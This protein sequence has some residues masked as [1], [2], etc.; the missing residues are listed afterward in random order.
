MRATSSARLVFPTPP[1]PTSNRSTLAWPSGSR[2]P[3]PTPTRETD[4]DGWD[5]HSS[6]SVV[7]SAAPVGVLISDVDGRIVQANDTKFTTFI[8]DF[9][10]SPALARRERFRGLLLPRSNHEEASLV[11][12]LLGGVGNL[13]GIADLTFQRIVGYVYR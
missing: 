7:S 3:A 12:S 10:I 6:A 13:F 8:S 11:A 9:T 5:P 2:L 1:V 4:I